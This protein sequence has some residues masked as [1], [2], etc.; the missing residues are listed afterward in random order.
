MKKYNTPE[1][2]VLAFTAEEP[3]AAA[4]DGGSNSFNDVELDW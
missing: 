1:L 4:R 3:I 2:K